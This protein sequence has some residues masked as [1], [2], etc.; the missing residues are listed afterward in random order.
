MTSV[1]SGEFNLIEQIFGLILGLSWIPLFY[2][3]KS[4]GVV[5]HTVCFIYALCSTMLG[6][7]LLSGVPSFLAGEVSYTVG[8]F[9]S[10]LLVFFSSSMLLVGFCSICFALTLD[11]SSSKEKVASPT[12]VNI[13]YFFISMALSISFSVTAVQHSFH[14]ESP[15]YEVIIDKNYYGSSLM[16]LE[17]ASAA[18]GSQSA[19]IIEVLRERCYT[20]NVAVY[21]PTSSLFSCVHDGSSTV[22]IPQNLFAVFRDPK[23][24]FSDN[25]RRVTVRP[26]SEKYLKMTIFT[27]DGLPPKSRYEAENIQ[28]IIFGNSKQDIESLKND[29]HWKKLAV[30]DD[31]GSK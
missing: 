18:E 21:S 5:V 24:L 10:T 31:E 3:T 17:E 1:I 4:K 11:I 13:Y 27:T 28:D 15:R 6:F 14:A 30:V 19:K 26:F 16:K 22:T 9:A 29:M 20:A 8:H 23:T 12:P 2:L 7:S 25:V